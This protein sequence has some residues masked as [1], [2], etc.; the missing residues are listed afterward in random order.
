MK[1]ASTEKAPGAKAT[2][3]SAISTLLA[4]KSSR[5]RIG[6][7]R[8]VMNANIAE[9]R[10]PVNDDIHDIKVIFVDELG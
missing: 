1:S 4:R 3:L 7:A 9:Y 2:P 10:V 6:F 8:I 5:A